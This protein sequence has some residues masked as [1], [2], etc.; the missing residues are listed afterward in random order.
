VIAIATAVAVLV[1]AGALPGQRPPAP[2]VTPLP[3]EEMAGRQAVVETGLGAFVI[4]RL[5]EQ[6]PNHVGYFMKLAEKGAYE[7]TIFHRVIPGSTQSSP[8]RGDAG[9]AVSPACDAPGCC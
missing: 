8:S 1:A 7:G 3:L 2:F 9:V 6:A 5:P 4:E